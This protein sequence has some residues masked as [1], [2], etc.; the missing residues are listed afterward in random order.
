M[1]YNFYTNTIIH[2]MYRNY[3]IFFIGSE[4]AFAAGA[5]IAEMKDRSFQDC[6]ARKFLS[7]WDVISKCSKPTIAAV[8][9]YALGGGCEVAMMCDIIYAGIIIVQ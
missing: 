8:N 5:D 4:R 6:Y 1:K 2:T 3:L 7:H 9:G